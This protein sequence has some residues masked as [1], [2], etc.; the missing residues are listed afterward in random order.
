MEFRYKIL[1]GENYMKRVLE[2]AYRS[3]GRM[4]PSEGVS[5]YGIYPVSNY[6]RVTRRAEYRL[7]NNPQHTLISVTDGVT[8]FIGN[9]AEVTRVL[10]EY[11]S[12]YHRIDRLTLAQAVDNVTK[13]T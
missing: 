8:E 9:Y 7:R 13:N 6:A 1:K 4:I 10:D 11:S 2:D 12:H 3:E 5:Y